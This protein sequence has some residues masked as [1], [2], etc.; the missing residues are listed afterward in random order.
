M[1]NDFLYYTES[2][3]QDQIKNYVRLQNGVETIPSIIRNNYHLENMPR[4]K[5]RGR[6]F[7]GCKIIA[8]NFKNLFNY[9]KGL[10][11]Y[12]PNPVIV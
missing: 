11:H 4:G 3:H 8:L 9:Q 6:F 10:G 5:Q 12:A 2:R 7:F 1:K